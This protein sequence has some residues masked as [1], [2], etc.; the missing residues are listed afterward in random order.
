VSAGLDCTGLAGGWGQLTAFH[1][2]DLSVEA[3]TMHA[4]LGPN[5]AGKTTL[6]LTLA[7]L[8]PPQA[9]T[10]SVAGEELR[11][12]RPTVACRAGLVLVPDNRQLFT[13]LT[14]EENLRV[15]DRRGT[16][17]IEAMYKL[18]PALK[19]RRDL[20]AGMLSGGE[21]QMLAVARAMIQRP[22]VLLV[23]ELSMGLAPTIVERLFSA[24]RQAATN[25][26][27]A[28]V[29][30][31]QYV[32]LA[33]QVA[34]T[35]SVINRGG[36]VMQGPAAEM[37]TKVSELEQAYLGTGDDTGEASGVKSPPSVV[38]PASAN[39]STA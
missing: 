1:D 23:D 22:K 29:F 21:Q 17:G 19:E 5:G 20:R 26:G 6:L 31:E 38:S 13:T 37:A 39:G 7:G 36:I 30:V 27:C 18:F 11:P 8:L 12:G 9:G 35:A 24:V 4:L 10:I 16:D 2:I 25:R 15:P 32:H 34:D 14:V 28:V 3:G 33:L